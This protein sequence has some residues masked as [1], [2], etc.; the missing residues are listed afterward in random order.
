VANGNEVMYGMVFN[1]THRDYNLKGIKRHAPEIIRVAIDVYSNVKRTLLAG[2]QVVVHR[3]DAE[4]FS[5]R[6][7]SE[8]P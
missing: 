5:K 7:L 3:N 6:Y 8:N 1:M 2:E 4:E